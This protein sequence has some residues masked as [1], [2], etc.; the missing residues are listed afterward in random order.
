MP[1]HARHLPPG[2]AREIAPDR[3]PERAGAHPPGHVAWSASRRR[4]LD[5]CERAYYWRYLGG[6]GGFKAPKGSEAWRAWA[7]KHLTA[8]P[9]LTGTVVH[10]AARRLLLGRRDGRP[11]PMTAPRRK[12]GEGVRGRRAFYSEA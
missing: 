5:E 4:L 2:Q 9:L 1:E 7:L 11:H 10:A 8:L 6:R 12:K 3:A